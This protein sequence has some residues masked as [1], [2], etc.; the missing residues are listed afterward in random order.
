MVSVNYILVYFLYE[1]QHIPLPERSPFVERKTVWGLSPSHV[2]LFP[3]RAPPAA[4]QA[5]IQQVKLSRILIA[6]KT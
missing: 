5:E 2:S 3:K 6:R 4:R 1:F